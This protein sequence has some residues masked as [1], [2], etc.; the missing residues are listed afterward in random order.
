MSRPEKSLHFNFYCILSVC[1]FLCVLVFLTKKL[2]P[3]EIKKISPIKLQPIQPNTHGLFT[4]QRIKFGDH[5]NY[6]NFV[7]QSTILICQNQPMR[8]CVNS[9]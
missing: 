3:E 5:R 8:L 1:V 6:I 4:H 2:N 9:M 7:N